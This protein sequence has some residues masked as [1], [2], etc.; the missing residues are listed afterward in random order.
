MSNRFK[1][2]GGRNPRTHAH[3]RRGIAMAVAAIGVEVATLWSRGYH[4]GGNVVVRCREGHLFTTIWIPGA[5]VKSLRLGP[6]RVQRCPVGHHWS[7][8]TP[9]RR[10]DLNQEQLRS[11]VELKDI[12]IP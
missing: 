5:S 6:W 10:S 9:S 1:R 4:L 8:V 7:I 11:A 12:R 2:R 3:R